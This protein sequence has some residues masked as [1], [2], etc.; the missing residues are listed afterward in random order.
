MA[1][2]KNTAVASKIFIDNDSNSNNNDKE[3]IYS[4]EIPA[5]TIKK[6]IIQEDFQFTYTGKHDHGVMPELKEGSGIYAALQKAKDET[7]LYLSKKVEEEK[8]KSRNKKEKIQMQQPERKK[9]KLK[10]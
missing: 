7:N 5:D 4:C 3:V 1:S 2:A 9:Q 8:I 6:D 10:K